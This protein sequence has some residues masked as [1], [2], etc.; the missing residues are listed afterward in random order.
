MRRTVTIA[1]LALA[2][3]CFEDGPVTPADDLGIEEIG[4][5]DV[6]AAVDLTDLSDADRERVPRDPGAGRESIL[7]LTED[8]R[9]EV[10][11]CAG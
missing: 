10:P 7:D 9:A 2:V 11:F 8:Q 3:A 1:A 6:V 4:E 5:G